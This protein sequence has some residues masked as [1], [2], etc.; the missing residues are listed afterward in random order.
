MDGAV[1][2][3]TWAG[4]TYIVVDNSNATSF[5]NGTD[6]VIKLSGVFDL[7]ASSITS[8]VLTGLIG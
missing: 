6:S 3:F 4:D 7:S 2:W 8:N 1:K 5:V